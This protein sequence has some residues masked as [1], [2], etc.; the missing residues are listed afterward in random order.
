[1]IHIIVITG[2]NRGNGLELATQLIHRGHK[3][4]KTARKPEESTQLKALRSDV[5][6]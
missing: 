5:I 2:T 1:M 6:G 4:I 3:I